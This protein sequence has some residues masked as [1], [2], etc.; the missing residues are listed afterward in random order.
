VEAQQYNVQYLSAK[1]TRMDHMLSERVAAE[2]SGELDGSFCFWEH[3]GEP[4]SAG[5]P[6]RSGSLD[7]SG[8]LDD[9]GGS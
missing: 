9:G 1:R 5:I 6:L 7:G 8:S 4:S 3:E 2:E